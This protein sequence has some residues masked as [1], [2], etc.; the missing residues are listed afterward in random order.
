MKPFAK[1]VLAFVVFGCGGVEG[2]VS[3]DEA[4]ISVEPPAE[5]Q[6][7]VELLLIDS[8]RLIDEFA[9]LRSSLPSRDATI[10]VVRPLPGRLHKLDAPTLDLFQTALEHPKFGDALEHAPCAEVDAARGLQRLVG[11]GFLRFA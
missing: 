7:P 1:A 11:L 4:E 6:E 3:D 5:L 8:L 10:S 9:A 2:T